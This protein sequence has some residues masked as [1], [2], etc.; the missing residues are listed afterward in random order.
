ML[1]TAVTLMKSN[2]AAVGVT[3]DAK[4]LAWTT[5]WDL[6][7]SADKSKRQDIFLYYWWP[8]YADPYSWFVN[9][10]RSADPPVWNFSYW[11]DPAMDK[12]IDGLQAL[13]ATDRAKAEQQYV[14]LQKTVSDQALS[15]VLGV[16]VYQ[17]ALS[18][19]VQGYVDNP[20]YTGVVFVHD[21]TVQS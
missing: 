18:S 17:R 8:E 14:D 7:K 2:L 11:N 16:V 5:Q 6:G 1:E 20:A 13:T 9:L 3:L 21:L 12:V 10:Y 4:P 15:P 19:S